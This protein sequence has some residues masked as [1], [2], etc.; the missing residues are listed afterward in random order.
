MQADELK[1]T[2]MAQLTGAFFYFAGR[3]SCHAYF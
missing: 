2:D 3:E 1:Q